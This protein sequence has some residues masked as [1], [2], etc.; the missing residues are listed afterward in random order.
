MD[1]TQAK[2]ARKNIRRTVIVLLLI[3]VVILVMFTYNVIRKA[4]GA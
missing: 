1:E 4:G 3:V 2:Q